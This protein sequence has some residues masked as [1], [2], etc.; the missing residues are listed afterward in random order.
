M[1]PTFLIFIWFLFGLPSLIAG[2]VLG[3]ISV[4]G[5]RLWRLRRRRAYACKR[6]TELSS[7]QAA[8]SSPAVPE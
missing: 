4:H 8:V 6:A 3:V 1:P 2:F 5:R 7:E